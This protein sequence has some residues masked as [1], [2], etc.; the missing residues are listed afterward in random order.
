[1]KDFDCKRC[2]HRNVCPAYTAT[3]T[4]CGEYMELVTCSECAYWQ[5][6]MKACGSLM[7]MVNSDP[8]GFCSKAERKEPVTPCR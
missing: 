2:I 5:E 4:E 7:G 6:G 3:M 1:M 8:R